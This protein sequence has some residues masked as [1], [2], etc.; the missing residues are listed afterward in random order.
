MASRCGRS[1]NCGK[2]SL[3]ASAQRRS[4]VMPRRR[5][6]RHR[7]D[8]RTHGHTHA[9]PTS[10]R[11]ACRSCRGRRVSGG[12]SIA[13][14]GWN[15]FGGIASVGW[16]RFGGLGSLWW[17]GILDTR[18]EKSDVTLGAWTRHLKNLKR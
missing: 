11:A 12:R 6:R 17:A 10:C 9:R 4:Y 2:R 3:M 13:S 1:P 18:Q 7:T 5:F 16:D 15:R 14:V 8:G